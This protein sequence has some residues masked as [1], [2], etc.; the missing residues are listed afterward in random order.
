[1]R[2]P[3]GVSD[4][5]LWPEFLELDRILHSY[6]SDVTTRLIGDHVH[7][8]TSDAEEVAGTLVGPSR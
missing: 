2:L 1:M 3:R 5:I 8:D 4:Q 7:A 6:L